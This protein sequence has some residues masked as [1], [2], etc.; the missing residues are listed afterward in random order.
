MPLKKRQ[1]NIMCLPMEGDS[2]TYEVF[3]P[4]TSHTRVWWSLSL[5][6]TSHKTLELQEQLK[7]HHE[8]GI[9]TVYTPGSVD[10]TLPL[11]HTEKLPRKKQR[12]VETY[13]LSYISEI[14]NNCNFLCPQWQATPGVPHS[15]GP[16]SFSVKGG[17]ETG[18]SLNC[19]PALRPALGSLISS[20][21]KRR[22]LGQPPV[23]VTTARAWR[24]TS[25]H[26]CAL[27]NRRRVTLC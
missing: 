18:W 14:A 17:S 27:S 15:L 13:I 19:L 5:N 22:L 12:R 10:R 24:G 9:D 11:C 7:W 25:H 16:A 21:G 8:D 4:K 26:T 1:P 23:S 6:I 2:C 3:P 20:P